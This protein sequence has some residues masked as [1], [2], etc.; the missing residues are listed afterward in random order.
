MAPHHERR[1]TITRTNRFDHKTHKKVETQNQLMPIKFDQPAKARPIVRD[2]GD[3]DGNTHQIFRG[4]VGG[5][6]SFACIFI[7]VEFKLS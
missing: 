4:F 7:S 3:D 1:P 2:S 6:V 5:A